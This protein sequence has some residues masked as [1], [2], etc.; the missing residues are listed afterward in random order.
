MRAH[1]PLFLALLGALVPARA[2]AQSVPYQWGVGLS[3]GTTVLPY[4]FPAAFPKVVRDDGGFDKV[5]SDLALGFDGLYWAGDRSRLGADLGFG[6]GSGYRELHGIAK[7]DFMVPTQALDWFFGSGLGAGH[8]WWSQGERTMRMP[9]FPLRIEAGAMVRF[10]V[11][12]IQ[13]ATYGQIDIPGMTT[14]TGTSGVPGDVGWGFYGHLGVELTGYYG[15]FD[16]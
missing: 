9:Y 10:P 13:V 8:A 6:F 5:R 11:F 4:R 7:Y 16:Q 1:H 3:A 12:A 15:R 2:L 14:Y